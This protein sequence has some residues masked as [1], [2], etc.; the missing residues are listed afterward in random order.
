MAEGGILG[1]VE[2]VVGIE[3]HAEFPVRVHCMFGEP[4]GILGLGVQR[5]ENFREIT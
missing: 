4:L 3:N 1:H 2:V 5:F